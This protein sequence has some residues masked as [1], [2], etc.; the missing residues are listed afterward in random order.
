MTLTEREIV[1]DG[2]WLRH[3]TADAL[4]RPPYRNHL[5]ASGGFGADTF[6]LPPPMNLF[7]TQQCGRGVAVGTII[8]VHNAP[9]APQPILVN[10][11]VGVTVGTVAPAK[12][13][14]FVLLTALGEWAPL[15]SARDNARGQVVPVVAWRMEAQIE[16][17]RNNFNML[18]HAVANG[19]DGT[20]PAIFVVT[21]LPG[22]VFGSTS[23][24]LP[25]FCTDLSAPVGGVSWHA[26]SILVW[27][28][29]AEVG[30]RGGAGG[31]G[32]VGG[33]GAST[34]TVGEDG[35]RAVYV[36]HSLTLVNAGSIRGGGGGGG[37]GNGSAG[38]PGLHGGPGG[39]G[40]GC[41]VQSNGQVV[42]GAPGAGATGTSPAQWGS[43]SQP[44][45]GGLSTTVGG[46]TGGYGGAG[47]DSATAGSPGL[48]LHNAGPGSAGGAAGP[49]IVRASAAT[50]TI[51]Q[52]GTI[53]GATVVV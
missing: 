37:G 2:G 50:L 5:I 51:V 32:G 19:Y 6:Y 22:S 8:W 18:E 21:C 12:S 14:A 39:G 13:Q 30:G 4:L 44:G 17:K 3:T 16:G 9:D 46:N 7:T 47:G 49:A 10:S 27:R 33:T 31:G 36:G 53:V 35:G 41:F 28:N 25:S 40:R 11:A 34:G 26:S 52:T 48:T 20:I 45:S 24:D 38:T 1:A 43:P 15:M 42:G 29:H 23:K